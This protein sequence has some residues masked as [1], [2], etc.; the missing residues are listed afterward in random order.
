MDLE[1]LLNK[2]QEN[3]NLDVKLKFYDKDQYSDL[4]KDVVSFANCLTAG[5]KYI[6]FGIEDITFKVC[7]I[8]DELPDISHL[9]QIIN[10]YVVV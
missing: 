4:V 3:D 10:T 6:V 8:D 9:Q 7:G 1:T 5:D 2:K